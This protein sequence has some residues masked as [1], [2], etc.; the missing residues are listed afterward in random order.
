MKSMYK[1]YKTMFQKNGQ[2]DIFQR[3]WHSFIPLFENMND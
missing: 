3:E 1:A 2:F